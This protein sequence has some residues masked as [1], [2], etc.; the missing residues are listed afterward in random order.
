[1][2][3]GAPNGRKIT[4]QVFYCRDQRVIVNKGP[5]YIEPESRGIEARSITLEAKL[6]EIGVADDN[7]NEYAFIFQKVKSR[8]QFAYIV[9]FTSSIPWEVESAAREFH[10]LRF[11][12]ENSSELV[13][14]IYQLSICGNRERNELTARRIR[15]AESKG[16]R[17]VK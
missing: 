14:T 15:K 3:E 8:D 17:R 2:A 13:G 6:I 11:T 10:Q 5:H 9:R 7:R 1:M 12:G 16:R 4:R